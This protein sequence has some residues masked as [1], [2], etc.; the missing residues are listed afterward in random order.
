MQIA[1][2]STHFMLIEND[3]LKHLMNSH[4]WIH[5]SNLCFRKDA[6]WNEIVQYKKSRDTE[7]KPCLRASLIHILNEVRGSLF[8]SFDFFT[9]FAIFSNNFFFTY[10]ISLAFA[11]L[12]ISFFLT[13]YFRS[14]FSL[15]TCC[16]LSLFLIISY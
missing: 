13:S 8:C 2:L 1:L 3:R 10:N 5:Y 9:N 14:S 12:Y 7:F 11:F 15:L 6:L 4:L 16:S